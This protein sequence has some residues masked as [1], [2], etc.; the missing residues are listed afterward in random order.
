[1]NCPGVAQDHWMTL[2]QSFWFWC[3]RKES[4]CHELELL[5]A[6]NWP[7][8]NADCLDLLQIPTAAL[9]QRTDMDMVLSS[10]VTLFILPFPRM[11]QEC[12]ICCLLF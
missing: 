10:S 5:S 1:M 2:G 8:V 12:L 9:N 7:V 4:G 6:L 11:T 3:L